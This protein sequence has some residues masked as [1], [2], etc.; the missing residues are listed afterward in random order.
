MPVEA[1]K[2]KSSGRRV[3]EAAIRP[4][5]E[6]DARAVIS[7]KAQLI[8]THKITIGAN[9][10]V[11]PYAKLDST[12]GPVTIGE[13]C[14]VFERAVVGVSE[15]SASA[16]EGVTLGASVCINS[17]AKVEAK[18]VGNGTSVEVCGTLCAGSV[19]GEVWAPQKGLDTD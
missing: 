7:D 18:S 2:T 5:C 13:Y 19:V 6:I 4:P 1:E 14:I 16:T 11:H 12:S 3:E 10:V 8:G 9:A 15:Q 17:R